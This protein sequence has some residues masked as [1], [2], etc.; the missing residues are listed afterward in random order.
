MSSR[1]LQLVLGADSGGGLGG[2][3]NADSVR[4]LKEMLAHRSELQVVFQG[5]TL[6]VR[7]KVIK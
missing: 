4:A 2:L 1:L 6:L 5:L 7:N 3:D